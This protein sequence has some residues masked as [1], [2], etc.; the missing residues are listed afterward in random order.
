MTHLVSLLLFQS[1][2]YTY[3]FQGDFRSTQ[4]LSK[5]KVVVYLIL[6]EQGLTT[7]SVY[8]SLFNYV[9]P[10]QRFSIF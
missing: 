6:I 2:E 4:I 1:L 10:K 5:S 9:K 8:V 7:H 3:I